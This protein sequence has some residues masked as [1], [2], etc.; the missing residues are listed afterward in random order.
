MH[1][2]TIRFPED[3]WQ[4]LRRSAQG[5]L[6]TINSE[7]MWILRE[8]FRQRTN[9]RGMGSVRMAAADG[10]SA[11]SRSWQARSVEA[12]CAP[13]IDVGPPLDLWIETCGCLS[14]GEITMFSR[15]FSFAFLFVL[16]LP[17][18]PAVGAE[19]EDLS[20]ASH[21]VKGKV[22]G[23]FAMDEDKGDYVFTTY[24][25]EIMIDKLEKGEG[26]APGTVVYLRRGV[27]SK[28][29]K[30]D[31]AVPGWIGLTSIPKVGDPVRAHFRREANGRCEVLLHYDAVK[32]LEK[33]KN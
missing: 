26:H 23:V 5:N 21:V 22:T 7:L 25:F 30:R 14:I 29:T 1:G 24:V 28:V 11:A 3:L 6:R 15:R 13:H 33:R 27:I 8:H 12:L 16:A 18:G 17:V 19:P 20:N 32:L 4:Q 31:A 9:L 10:A 2:R